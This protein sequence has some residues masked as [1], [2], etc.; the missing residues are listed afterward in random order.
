MLRWIGQGRPAVSLRNC[1]VWGS[2]AV[3]PKQAIKYK[4]HRL[5]G[6]CS[7]TMSRSGLPRTRRRRRRGMKSR[8]RRPQPQRNKMAPGRPRKQRGRPWR[9]GQRPGKRL[10]HGQ[11]VPQQC[12]RRS[13]WLQ[14]RRAGGKRRRKSQRR[15]K[16]RRRR[17]DGS[18]RTRLRP[19]RSDIWRGS[20]RRRPNDD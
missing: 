13:D 19:P 3:T 12:Q 2:K 4:L 15:R 14:K 8:R 6:T 1:E 18:G 5:A 9:R 10:P 17:S 20:A 7:A 16:R 11:W